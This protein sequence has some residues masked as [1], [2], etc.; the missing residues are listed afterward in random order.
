MSCPEGLTADRSTFDRRDAIQHLIDHLPTGMP[1]DWYEGAADR[2][3][4]RREVVYLG[5]DQVCGDRYS[6]VDLLVLERRLAEQVATRRLGEWSPVVK[7]SIA[8]STFVE[9]PSMT[10]EQRDLVFGVCCTRDAVSVVVAGPGT[11]KTF[12]LDSARDAFQRAGYTTI[13]CALSASAAHQ[14]Q[15]GSGSG[16]TRSPNSLALDRGDIALGP[17]VV[18]VVDEAGD[19]RHPHTSPASSTTPPR[20]RQG[21]AR[22]RPPPAPRDRRRRRS[23]AAS[24]TRLDAIHLTDNRRQHRR[25]GTRRPRRARARRHRRRHRRI[26]RPRPHHTKRRPTIAPATHGRGLDDRTDSPTTRRRHG[27]RPPRRR[28][29]PQPPRP[30]ALRRSHGQLTGPALD[31]STDARSRR[32]PRS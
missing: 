1:A 16:P 21:R 26:P 12:C 9:R 19:G 14:L 17:H 23:S 18:L 15:Q 13:G 10:Q 24:A 4:D 32:R 6:T 29:R 22:R 20:R 7:P 8:S 27:R 28:R 5:V 11:G 3:L 2:Y 30:P 31:R 25:L